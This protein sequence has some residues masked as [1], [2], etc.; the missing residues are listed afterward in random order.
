[1]VGI[2]LRIGKGQDNGTAVSSYW[3]CVRV[4]C[5]WGCAALGVRLWPFM[6][7]YCIGVGF[8]EGIS[9]LSKKYD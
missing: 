1:M 5:A 2:C 4:L 9:Y 8:I 7:G 3:V 6:I